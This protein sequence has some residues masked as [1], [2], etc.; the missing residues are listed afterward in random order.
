MK[1]L[2]KLTSNSLLIAALATCNICATLAQSIRHLPVMQRP[3][4]VSLW[5]LPLHTALSKISDATGVHLMAAPD[6]MHYRI[7]VSVHQQPLLNVMNEIVDLFGHGTIPYHDYGWA[8]VTKPDGY[9]LER[10]GEAI[11]QEQEMLKYPA[12]ELPHELREI[13]RFVRLPLQDRLKLKSSG[14]S[15]IEF[16]LRHNGGHLLASTSVTTDALRVITRAQLKTLLQQGK[17]EVEQCHPSPLSMKQLQLITRKSTLD[18]PNTSIRVAQ[19]KKPVLRLVRSMPGFMTSETGEYQL[20]L[21][22]T[23]GPPQYELTYITIDP[24]HLHLPLSTTTSKIASPI[25][26]IRPRGVTVP[27]IRTTCQHALQQLAKVSGMQIISEAFVALPQVLMHSKGTA[28]GILNSICRSYGYTWR[29]VG[30]TYLVYSR[31]WAQ[32]RQADIPQHVLDAW[33]QSIS[34][35]GYVTL[36]V[37]G[38]MSRMTKWQLPTITFATGYQIAHRTVLTF[39]NTLSSPDLQ[40]SSLRQGFTYFPTRYA[41]RILW[42]IDPSQLTVPPYTIKTRVRSGSKTSLPAHASVIITDARGTILTAI[43]QPLTGFLHDEDDLVRPA[44]GA[45][46]VANMQN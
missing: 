24:L 14:C 46:D 18:P 40:E 43:R 37:L 20:L 15:W 38:Q 25:I 10:N 34:E 4:T 22:Y 13:T 6:L 27:V 9:L 12:V 1:A 39:L 44:R 2:L 19:F 45:R 33:N 8:H 16:L 21:Q 29:K 7:S 36:H 5:S 35:H 31:A 30:D 41:A 28:E 17:V 11:Q 32:N 26:T 42:K 3:V 23:E